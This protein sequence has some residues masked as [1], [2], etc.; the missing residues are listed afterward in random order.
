MSHQLKSGSVSGA[1]QALLKASLFA[2]AA[3]TIHQAA[4]EIL[5]FLADAPDKMRHA[6]QRI[7]YDGRPKRPR[8][9]AKGRKSTDFTATFPLPSSVTAT[10]SGVT[11]SP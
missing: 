11:S 8:S 9:A 7:R 4:V 3:S 10:D 5:D 6:P 2:A 1:L